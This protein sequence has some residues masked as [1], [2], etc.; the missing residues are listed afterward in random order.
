MESL[1][2]SLEDSKIGEHKR[3]VQ[4]LKMIDDGIYGICADCDKK[5]SEKRLTL[6]PNAT[7][8][9]TCQEALE[10]AGF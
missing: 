4:A 3:L 6:F 9:L 1:R 10:E 2:S 7:R 5:I 8:C